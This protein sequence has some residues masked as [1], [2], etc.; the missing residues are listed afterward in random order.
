MP[1]S[2]QRS[3]HPRRRLLKRGLAIAGWAIPASLSAAQLAVG[4]MAL[5]TGS[6]QQAVAVAPWDVAAA[7]WPTV[8]D[9]SH[10]QQEQI[11]LEQWLALAAKTGVQVEV[12]FKPDVS[13]IPISKG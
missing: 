8:G 1:V 7:P 2:K 4:I 9:E 6:G 5:G 3:R 11:R 12:A 13:Y 10:L